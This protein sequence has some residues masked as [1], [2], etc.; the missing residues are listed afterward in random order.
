MCSSFKT[1]SVL[2]TKAKMVYEIWNNAILFILFKAFLRKASVNP[3][4][5][6]FPHKKCITKMLRPFN[7]ADY[8]HSRLQIIIIPAR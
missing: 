2:Y 3:D 7:P 4:Y 1:L 5:F 6:H 8:S